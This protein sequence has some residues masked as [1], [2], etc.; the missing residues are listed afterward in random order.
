[1]KAGSSPRQKRKQGQPLLID[2]AS[3]VLFNDLEEPV[4]LI[5]SAGQIIDTNAAARDFLVQIDQTPDELPAW[6]ADACASALAAGEA[7]T[8]THHD[9]T[10]PRGPLH[11]QLTCHLVQRDG[12]EPA[13]MVVAR[14]ITPLKNAEKALA[15]EGEF[16]SLVSDISSR[17]VGVMAHEFD[18]AITDA[19]GR[20]ADFT[21]A[22]SAYIF[23][24]SETGEQFT[25]SHLW[26]DGA[27]AAEEDRLTDL[28]VNTMPWWMNRLRH[29]EVV[30]VATLDDLPPE[31]K[32]EKEIIAEQEIKALVDV[33]LSFK[34]EVIGFMGLA[35]RA[36]ERTWSAEEVSLLRIMGQVFTNALQHKR[37][38]GALAQERNLLRTVIDNLPDYIYA[39][40]ARSR[41]ILNNKAHRRLLRAKS[42]EEI[43]QKNDYD[44]FPV[45]LADQ[46]FHDE[47]D[48]IRTAKPLVNREE[49]VIT[50][51]GTKRWLLTTKVPLVDDDGDCVGIVGMSRDITVR[52]EMAEALESHA[53]LL[54]QVNTDLRTRNQELDEF[55]YIASHD[56]QE[57]LRKLVAFSDVLRDDVEAA[58]AEEIERDLG[59]ISSAARRMQTLVKDLLALSRSGRQSMHFDR[60]DLNECVE[61][62][63][64]ALEV[65]ITEE[66]AEI[67][68]AAL[69]VVW[70]DRTLLTQLYQN[71]ISNA[72]KFHG[73]APPCVSLTLEEIDDDWVLGVADRGIG[74]KPEYA[75]QIFAP[76]KRLHGRGKYDGT[77]IGLAICRKIVERHGGKIW[78]ESTPGQGAHF[79][80]T[81]GKPEDTLTE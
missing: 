48:V 54:E 75:E 24:F 14:N 59:I 32:V 69:P 65:R 19:L 46:Y 22:D 43:L 40:D 8:V 76:F 71:L 35:C 74:L 28:D 78:V 18:A 64:E 77:G 26:I 41:F 37:A 30:S 31:A 53:K 57:P 29:G 50:E 17:F 58:N 27:P 67:D 6:L 5:D 16:A 15:R 39:K 63:R 73:D 81:L 4:L 7:Y 51:E 38:E 45:E 44:I 1:M 21:N 23:Q 11:L 36:H 70:G 25:M 60:I 62:A 10:T 47:Q 20:I 79:K 3:R 13:L 55:T 72:V 68:Q 52:K 61:V 66:E 12:E 80:F 33:P 34:N 49:S 42:P 9:L 56:L 2:E